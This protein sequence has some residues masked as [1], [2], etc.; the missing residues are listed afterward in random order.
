MAIVG[1]GAALADY[2]VNS[3][4]PVVISDDL[5][6]EMTGVV[7]TTSAEGAAPI[8]GTCVSEGS[9][10]VTITDWNK[11]KSKTSKT[12]TTSTTVCGVTPTATKTTTKTSKTTTTTT[13]TTTK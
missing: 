4:E 9:A 3:G 10:G 11:T 7:S 8:D 6:N 1:G 2:M 5:T 12:A 13:T